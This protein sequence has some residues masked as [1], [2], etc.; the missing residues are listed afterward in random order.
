MKL[1]RFLVALMAAIFGTA[2]ATTA[3]ATP[4]LYEVTHPERAG[5]AW[6]AGTI[7]F[8]D[9]AA[10][11]RPA[12]FDRVFEEADS[13]WFEIDLT[14]PETTL[15]REMVAMATDDSSRLVAALP[16][17]KQLLALRKAAEANGM[18]LQ[19]LSGFEPWFVF[20]QW[21]ALLMNRL[22]FDAEHGV[23]NQYAEAAVEAGKPVSG[24][25]TLR[26]Q[27]GHFD[28]MEVSAQLDAMATFIA[29]LDRSETE[30]QRMVTA[31]KEGNDAEL[32]RIVDESW[33]Q[34]AV[35]NEA[36]LLKRNRN[37]VSTLD[38]ELAT[39]GARL[40][41]VGAGHLVGRDSLPEMLRERGYSVVRIRD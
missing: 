25:E 17:T 37:W 4:P 23:E 8:M 7:H 41:M 26:E 19:Q 36:L 22:G 38:E 12:A 11:G 3:A 5:T 21:S 29:E 34:D 13:V 15:A 9:N 14:I 6:L 31:W 27:L 16:P 33:Q 32:A 39:S 20:L 40:V 24:L 1:A 28:R 30:M 18:P 35:L 2:I 10:D